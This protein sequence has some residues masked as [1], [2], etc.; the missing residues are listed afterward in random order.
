M[1]LNCTPPYGQHISNPALAYLKGFLEFHDIEAKNVYWNLVLAEIILKL[2]TGME[3][4]TENEDYRS[5]Y[6]AI[7]LSRQLLKSCQKETPLDT[8]Y[9]IRY[10]REEIGE[11]AH[12]TEEYIDEYIR[13]NRLHE[14]SLAGFTL[15]THQ[16]LLGYYLVSR[17]KTLN[18]SI[19]IVL[20]GIASEEQ[21]RTF[22]R[23]FTFADFAIWGEGE[24]PLLYL[25]QALEEGDVERVP[26]L[27]YRDN[28]KISFTHIMN[29]TPHLDEYPFANHSD[30]IQ[31][32]KSHMKGD[33][34]SAY[35]NAVGRRFGDK[36]PAALTIWGSR[37]CPWNKCKFC[38]LNENY[39]Y[40]VRSPE[41]IVKEI[42]YQS[43]AHGINT[44]IFVDTE[45]PGNLK[46]FKTLLKLIMQSSATYEKKYYFCAEISPAFVD[47]ETAKYMH[48]VSFNEIQVGFEAMT[49]TLL[50]KMEKRHRFAH[51]LQ[52]LKLGNMYGLQMIGLNIIKQIP[53]ETKED[54]LESCRNVKF[55]RFFLSKYSLNPRSLRLEKGSPFYEEVKEERNEWVDSPIWT[56]V[57]PL[58]LVKWEERYDF[59]GFYKP[60]QD[61]LWIDCE[62]IIKFF[63]KQNCSYE[64]IEYKAGSF[65]EERGLRLCRYTFDRD[66]TD[67]LLFCD[68]IKSY[69]EVKER[70]SH[71]SEE[72][73]HEMLYDMREAGFIYYD[74]ELKWIISVVEAG[75]RK[76]LA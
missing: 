23:L 71:L 13:K 61:L 70:F 12:K 8:L 20:G 48:L 52:A 4:Y 29:E 67:L 44:F 54:I 46:R 76:I 26:N 28:G 37:S 32:F 19:P 42:E 31:A 36:F 55:L 18:P 56:E 68:T 2:R 73:L 62:N 49:D 40:R 58:D 69:L 45:L 5:I 35:M 27:V 11:M 15:K 72:K 34:L 3:L 21:A 6:A 43:Q 59:F 25:A 65:V 7:Y 14:A 24:Y 1:I 75:K 38:A 33:S 74:E 41:N 16:W 60:F 57:E 66:E 39:T 17:F 10:S 64:W 9:S 47:E 50:R 63:T 51:N 53:G 30:Y 22:M